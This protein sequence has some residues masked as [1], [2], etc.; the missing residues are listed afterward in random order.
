MLLQAPDDKGPRFDGIASRRIEMKPDP[1][2]PVRDMAQVYGLILAQEIST[3]LRYALRAVS[4]E[5]RVRQLH[6]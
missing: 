3:S 2:Q 1:E 6:F 5:I 4:S